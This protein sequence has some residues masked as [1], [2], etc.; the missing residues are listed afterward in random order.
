M[1]HN[2]IFTPEAQ[3]QLLA[4]YHYTARVYSHDFAQRHIETILSYC[5]RFWAFRHMGIRRNDIRPGLR[6]VNYKKRVT[7]ALEVEEDRLSILG[8]FDSGQ[9]YEMLLPFLSSELDN[10]TERDSPSPESSAPLLI[11]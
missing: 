3:A 5:K 7:L 6:I 11:L 10:S 4:L 1:S 9:D 2:V 8:V